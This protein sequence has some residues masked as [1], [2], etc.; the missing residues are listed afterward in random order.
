M[1]WAAQCAGNWA[2]FPRNQCPGR[3]TYSDITMGQGVG[4]NCALCNYVYTTQLWHCSA[5]VFSS[6]FYHVLMQDRLLST[7]VKGY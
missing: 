4:G 6:V 3:V 7:A 5:A 2:G 1:V